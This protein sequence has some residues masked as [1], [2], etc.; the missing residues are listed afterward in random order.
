MEVGP[1]KHETFLEDVRAAMWR[2]SPK[3]FCADIH[4][5]MNSMVGLAEFG[6]APD[7]FFNDFAGTGSYKE[8][9]REG[10]VIVKFAVGGDIIEREI[11][12]YNDSTKYG[13]QQLFCPTEYIPIP[14]DLHIILTE[15]DEERVYSD[16]P[17]W[18][19]AEASN[20]DSR[21]AA[22]EAAYVVI[23]PYAEMRNDQ[24][25]LKT[26]GQLIGN[27]LTL[28]SGGVLNDNE[29]LSIDAPHEWRESVI[30]MYGDIMYRDMSWG[31]NR[32]NISDL[33][34]ANVGWIDKYP[35]ILDWLS[36][37]LPA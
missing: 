17:R 22:P 20:G 5:A 4:C 6:G 12:A 29:Y 24:Q 10:T 2:L 37:R 13:I 9:W 32:L 26:L 28:N 11:A 31:L 3:L 21:Y 34:I 36:Y 27:P 15:M 16:D 14:S 35:V 23:Q 1:I 25:E 7:T 33:S 30:D 19:A 18:Y 8:A